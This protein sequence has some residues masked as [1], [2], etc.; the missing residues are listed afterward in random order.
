MPHTAGLRGMRDWLLFHGDFDDRP[1]GGPGLHR[2]LDVFWGFPRA[3]EL[4]P[5]GFP[6][7]HLIKLP[8]E[9]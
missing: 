4:L 7:F 9:R 3:D 6:H 5:L 8:K 1:G 2:Y